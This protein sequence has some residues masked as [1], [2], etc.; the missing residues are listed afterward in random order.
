M[1]E[2]RQGVVTPIYKHQQK[3]K[4]HVLVGLYR[5]G[6]CEAK[7]TFILPEM[8][9]SSADALPYCVCSSLIILGISFQLLQPNEM[10]TKPKENNC[11]QICQT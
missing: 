9:S 4:I 8:H 7:L 1:S 6:F 5:H 3:K 2:S 11:T 10:L